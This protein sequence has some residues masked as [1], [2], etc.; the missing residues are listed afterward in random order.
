MLFLRPLVTTQVVITDRLSAVSQILDR[1]LRLPHH[2]RQ[3]PPEAG[4][5]VSEYVLMFGGVMV[6]LAS[7]AV[8]VFFPQVVNSLQGL[9]TRSLSFFSF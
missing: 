4:M 9:M 3:H 6:F 8:K 5:S 7:F 2:D 1:R